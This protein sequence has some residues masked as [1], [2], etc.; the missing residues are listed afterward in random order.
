MA[1]SQRFIVVDGSVSGHCCFSCSVIDTSIE[2][3]LL[4]GK[5]VVCECYEESS[6]KAIANAMN[7]CNWRI[8]NG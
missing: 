4:E 7:Q 8:K 6:A 3:D 2:K 1:A 5:H